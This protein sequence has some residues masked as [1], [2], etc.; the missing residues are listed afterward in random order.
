MYTHTCYLR[1]EWIQ[2]ECEIRKHENTLQKQATSK[3]KQKPNRQRPV[4]TGSTRCVNLA[5]NAL[6]K[7]MTSSVLSIQKQNKKWSVRMLFQYEKMN[8]ILHIDLDL[9]YEH[10]NEST[11]TFINVFGEPV[12]DSPR[13]GHVKEAHWAGYNAPEYIFMHVRRGYQCCLKSTH[14]ST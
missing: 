9:I 4:S 2:D 11:L 1:H 3:R 10:A 6:F 14:E 13:W 5:P 12:D 8:I 7:P